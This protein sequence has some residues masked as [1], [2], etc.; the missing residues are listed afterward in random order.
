MGDECTSDVGG[1]NEDRDLETKI[2]TF[3]NQNLKY[4]IKKY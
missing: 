3:K 2:N 4:Q 1:L